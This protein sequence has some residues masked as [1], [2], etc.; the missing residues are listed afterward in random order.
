[1]K[2]L[3][4]G[5]LACIT[6]ATIWYGCT[7]DYEETDLTGTIYGTV[8][9]FATGE[10]VANANVSL[11]P[12]G[13]STLT[14]S[15]GQFEFQGIADGNYSLVVSKAEYSTLMDDYIIVM[16]DGMRMRRDVQIK[17]LPTFIQ[18]F[19]MDGSVL[20]VLDFGSSASVVSKSFKL[21]N[22]GTVTI[23]CHANYNCNW[24]SSVSTI[25]NEIVPGQTITIT[26][27]INRSRLANG[28]NKTM[29]T[30]ASNNGSNEIEIRASSATG[31]PPVVTMSQPSSV[32][33]TSVFLEGS[34]ANDQGSQ[35][36][37]KGFCYSTSPNPTTNDQVIHLGSGSSSFSHT[38][39]D[40][41]S[42]RTYHV[43]AFA[44]TNLGTG[45]SSDMTFTTTSG[46]PDVGPTVIHSTYVTVVSCSSEVI[47]D[48]G[49]SVTNKG[50]CWSS[51]HTP[52][53]SDNVVN[54]GSGTGFFSEYLSSLQPSTTYRVRA[55]ATNSKGTAYG[56]EVTVT[57]LSGLATVTTKQPTRSGSTVST[58]GAASCDQCAIYDKGVCYGFSSNPNL[59]SLFEHTIDGY[60]DGSFTSQFTPSGHGTLH[61]RAYATTQYGTAYGEDKTIN[62]P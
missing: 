13:E 61:V 50:F 46:L 23:H 15:D 48:N 60:S 39:Y 8:T 37:S 44:T 26:V 9:D 58:G 22:N 6:M 4:F 28:E 19:D 1:M 52:T 27:S 62:I 2:K 55:F 16:K 57:T 35:V 5:L 34:I 56:P 25:P 32:T 31:N 21:F 54:A 47:S 24:I 10:P 3:L 20:Q 12:G 36:T 41:Q 49:F 29:L 7:K 18:F 43:R 30:I 40:L 11:R 14:G 42:N 59:S 38:V 45:Y 53:T 33:A 51:Q 17:K